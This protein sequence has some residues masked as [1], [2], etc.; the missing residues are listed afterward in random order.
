MALVGRP[1]F[2]ECLPRWTGLSLVSGPVG[3]S[4]HAPHPRLVHSPVSPGEGAQDLLSSVA[5]GQGPA[6]AAGP[7]L[8]PSGPPRAQSPMRLTSGRQC[9]APLCA[10]SGA[11]HP[12]PT[13]SGS[14]HCSA[15]RPA[16]PPQVAPTP[17]LSRLR[18]RPSPGHL[19]G[20]DFFRLFGLGSRS[21][22]GPTRGLLGFRYGCGRSWSSDRCSKAQKSGPWS[23][24]PPKRRAAP[25]AEK[26]R[27]GLSVGR[28]GAG[29]RGIV[30]SPEA[31]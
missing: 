6:L 27:S 10:G 17:L 31:A 21:T 29:G 28:V 20:S 14:G 7:N 9:S 15:P 26:R 12:A 11:P 4:G 22:P 8:G 30:D 24:L 18:A 5:P 23:R 19:P 13:A 25:R 2:S 16:G 1:R 3:S